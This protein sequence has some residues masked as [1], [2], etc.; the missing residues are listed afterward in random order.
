MSKR[1]IIIIILL[2]FFLA[3]CKEGVKDIKVTSCRIVSVVPEGLSSISAFIEVGIHNPVVGFEATDVRGVV[4]MKGQDALIVTADQLIVSGH[5]DKVY[6]L[7][8]KGSIAKG[9]N[10]FQLLKLI[11]DE[12]GLDQLT[13]SA[14][15]KVSLRNGLGKNLEIKDLPLSKL[16][17]E[18]K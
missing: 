11:D 16:L 10:P 17:E 18:K 2:T 6:T 12:A 9:F 7:P 1:Q 4:K 14:T 5:C 15:G 8:L 3:G 13:L